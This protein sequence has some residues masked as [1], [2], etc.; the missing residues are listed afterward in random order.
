MCEQC[1]EEGYRFPLR[2]SNKANEKAKEAAREA[3]RQS[4]PR[5]QRRSLCNQ[6]YVL[7][8]IPATIAYCTCQCVAPISTLH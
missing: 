8:A 4:G 2:M 1:L 5:P 7:L 3:R 6:W